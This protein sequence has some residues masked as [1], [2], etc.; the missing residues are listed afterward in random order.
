VVLEEISPVMPGADGLRAE[1]ITAGYGRA[2]IV[3]EVELTV[4][5]PGVSVILGRNGAGKTTLMNVFAGRHPASAGTVSLLGRDVTR[6]SPEARWR[7]GLGYMS[8]EECVFP[9]LNVRDNLRMSNGS[10]LGRRLKLTGD[11]AD[12][13]FELFPRLKERLDQPAGRLSGGERKL[14]AL[15]RTLLTDAKVIVLDE[16][17]E[18]VFPSVIERIAAVLRDEADRR[19]ILL[20]EQNVGFAM[21]LG[22]RTYV[23]D[24]GRIVLEGAPETLRDDKRLRAY[25]SP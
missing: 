1:G 16:P 15:S 11:G 20:V 17:T 25:V 10:S 4:P 3:N 9:N 18:G 23:M 22:G 13:C 7:L 24:R 12:R 6:M 2:T 14:L 5:Y 8:Q 21:S 19:S